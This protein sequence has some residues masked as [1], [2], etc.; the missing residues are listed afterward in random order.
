[1]I[2]EVEFAGIGKIDFPEFVTLM[3]RRMKEKDS[4]EDLIEV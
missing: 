1:M 4:K 3:V 2:N